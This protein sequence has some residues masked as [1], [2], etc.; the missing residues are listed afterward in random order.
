MSALVDVAFEL[1][2]VE[3]RH[4]VGD[5]YEFQVAAAFGLEGLL[6]L[7]AWPPLRGEAFIGVDGERV[8]RVGGHG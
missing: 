5:R 2:P 4:A 1:D 8:G 3:Q 7:R 6:D